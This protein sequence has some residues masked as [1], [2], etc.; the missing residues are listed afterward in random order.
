[1]QVRVLIDSAASNERVKLG[2]YFYCPLN[3]THNA[4]HILHPILMRLHTVRCTCT[5]NNN[6]DS[7]NNNN[8]NNNSDKCN[9][10]MNSNSNNNNND[11]NN[12]SKIDNNYT[13]KINNNVNDNQSN[14][15][16]KIDPK[17]IPKIVPH[18]T[19]VNS[20]LTVQQIFSQA[21]NFRKLWESFR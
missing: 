11:N 3:P 5:S 9:D 4:N 16:I 2:R 7:D 1:M 18:E 8:N 6:S 14:L 21:E 12:T 10:A 20:T 15:K 17:K 19:L 13:S